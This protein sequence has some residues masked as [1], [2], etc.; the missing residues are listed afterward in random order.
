MKYLLKVPFI[1]Q[2]YANLVGFLIFETLC[3]GSSKTLPYV[4]KKYHK[5]QQ[6]LCL[7]RHS[8]TKLSQNIY[9]TNTH[10]L[11]YWYARCDC[12]L[13]NAPRF[14]CAFLDIFKY[15]SR[16]IDVRIIVSSP[17]FYRLYVW[18]MC[19]FWYVNMSK[20]DCI[21]WKVFLFNCV[22]WEFSLYY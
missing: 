2:N 3:L 6:R 17:N 9:L 18:L 7:V 22:F 12:K 11:I 5:N 19:I 15:N 14:Y 13:C 10:I 21:S 16:T 20:C 4:W 1:I 8:F